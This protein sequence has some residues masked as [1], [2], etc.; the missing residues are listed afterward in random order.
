MIY[1]CLSGKLWYLQHNCVWDTIIYH[2]ASDIVFSFRNSHVTW[3]RNK[4]STSTFLHVHFH[5]NHEF[6]FFFSKYFDILFPGIK[7]SRKLGKSGRPHI[8]WWPGTSTEPEDQ[9]TPPWSCPTQV[10][11]CFLSVGCIVISFGHT[12]WNSLILKVC[13]QHSFIADTQ[14]LWLTEVCYLYSP[15]CPYRHCSKWTIQKLM[16]ITSMA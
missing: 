5:G 12:C 10:V 7:S 14:A 11:S 8:M 2:Q 13:S 16:K 9:K 1:R 6:L 15:Y 3:S 4:E